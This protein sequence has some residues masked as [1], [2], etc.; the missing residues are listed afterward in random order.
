MKKVLVFGSFDVIH[1]GHRSLFKQA[2]NYGDYLVVVVARDATY[3][4]LRGYKPVHTERERLA[5]VAGESLVDKAVLGD[6]KD[7]YKV[8]GQVRPQVIA[9]GYDQSLFV[10]KL[11]E[12]LRLYA[13]Q[14]TRIVRLEPFSPER[15]KSSL[16][17]KMGFSEKSGDN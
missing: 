13:L 10:D 3:E 8:L 5:A 14:A 12:K 4:G 15:F 2:K 16:M 9:L 17:K 1:D 7:P 6:S 11:E